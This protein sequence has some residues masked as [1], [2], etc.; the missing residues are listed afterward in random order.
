MPVYHQ[1]RWS[2]GTGCTWVIYIAFQH[3]VPQNRPRLWAVGVRKDTPGAGEG[4]RGLEIIPAELCLSLN[5][6]LETREESDTM[7]RLPSG[8]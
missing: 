1:G 7:E 4:F 6:I 2:M 3:G 5:E 8:P